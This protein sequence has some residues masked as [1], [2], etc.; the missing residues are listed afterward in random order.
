MALHSTEKSCEIEKPE[1]SVGNYERLSRIRE[2]LYQ[3][4]I[5]IGVAV[6]VMLMGVAFVAF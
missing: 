1:S 4:D 6:Y 2:R 5:W 3:S